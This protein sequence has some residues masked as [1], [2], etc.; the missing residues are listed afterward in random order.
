MFLLSIG[1]ASVY[2]TLRLLLL[3]SCGV[4]SPSRTT[5]L[6]TGEGIRAIRFPLS[7]KKRPLATRLATNGTNCKQPNPA[8]VLSHRHDRYPR[9][10]ASAAAH[11]QQPDLPHNLISPRLPG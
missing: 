3:L 6:K 1:K 5:V 10:D 8:R 11:R 7:F 2:P 4:G 9:Q